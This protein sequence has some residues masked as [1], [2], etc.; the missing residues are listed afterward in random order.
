MLFLV[1]LI[2]IIHHQGDYF[3]EIIFN[4]IIFLEHKIIILIKMQE[5]EF[6][7]LLQED[8]LEMEI[9]I[10]KIQIKKLTIYLEQI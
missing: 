4:L 10:L 1:L 3:Q 6:L 7:G 2:T 5:I 9:I 8:Y